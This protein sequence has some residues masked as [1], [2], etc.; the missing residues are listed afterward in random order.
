MRRLSSMLEH[1]DENLYPGERHKTETT[2]GK[3]REGGRRE[4]TEKGGKRVKTNTSEVVR[5]SGDKVLLSPSGAVAL[6]SPGSADQT[7][8]KWLT[9]LR[10]HL[11]APVLFHS[12]K[13]VG[14]SVMVTG[15]G[16]LLGRSA[17][18]HV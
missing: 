14:A 10:A 2:R 15:W 13:P 3:G 11:H 8:S 7:V 18:D 1:G 6:C 16:A 12:Q 9:L 17:A 5:Q 4:K